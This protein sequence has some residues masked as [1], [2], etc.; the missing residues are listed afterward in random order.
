MK[1]AYYMPFKPLGHP[2]PSGDLIIGTEL[3]TFLERNGHQIQLASSLRCRW[4]YR[5]PS[6]WWPF[7]RERRRVSKHLTADRPDIWLSYHSY[8]KAPDLLGPLCCQRLGIPYALFQGIYSTKRKRALKTYPGFILNRSALTRAQVVFTNKRHDEHN[9][10][11]LL[12]RERVVYVAPGIV[13]EQFTIDNEARDTIRRRLQLQ[14]KQVI[15]SAAMFRPGVKTEGLKQVIHSCTRLQSSAAPLHL[16]IAGEGQCRTELEHYAKKMMPDGVSFLGKIP[17][18]ELQAYYSSADIFAF[19]GI[20]EG[21]GMVYLEAQSCGLPVVAYRDWGASEA[22]V[23][24]HTGLLSAA[25]KPDDFTHNIGRLLK[26]KQLRKQLGNN[27]LHHVRQHHNMQT[28]Y[29]LVEKTL[30]Q[31]VA[32][33]KDKS[34]G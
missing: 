10:L 18:N 29:Q 8:Y 11:R 14:G 32:H 24:G 33:W 16:L 5:T 27:A 20:E 25:A 30:Q 31:I 12:P 4:L 2:T 15:M 26:E 9:L 34:S 21:L 7:L 1:I 3:Y 19:P 17:R 13:P 23:H 22:V 28:N 6:L